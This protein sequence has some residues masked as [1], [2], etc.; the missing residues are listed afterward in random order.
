MGTIMR[1]NPYQVWE[2]DAVEGWL[3]DMASQGYLLESRSGIHYDVENLRGYDN[4]D[5]TVDD[6]T[7]KKQEVALVRL[8]VEF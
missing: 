4:G 6:I 3:D 5:V 1:P 7:L 2:I 8:Y